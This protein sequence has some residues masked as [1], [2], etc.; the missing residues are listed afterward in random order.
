VTDFLPDASGDRALSSEHAAPRLLGAPDSET[1]QDPIG[2]F[3]PHDPAGNAEDSS[4]QCPGTGGKP[5]LS[6]CET[7]FMKWR[8]RISGR[9]CLFPEYGRTWLLSREILRLSSFP[10]HEDGLR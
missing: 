7:S 2:H 6:G 1:L 4:V 5:V 10:D 8:A 3:K 9:R